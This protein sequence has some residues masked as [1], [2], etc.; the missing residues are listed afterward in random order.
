[1]KIKLIR[2]VKIY[3]LIFV[4]EVVFFKESPYQDLL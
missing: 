3:K 4:G 1:M 2:D